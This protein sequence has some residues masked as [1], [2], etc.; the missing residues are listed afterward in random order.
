MIV[1]VALFAIFFAWVAWKRIRSSD[2]L[3]AGIVNAGKVRVESV[4][5]GNEPNSGWWAELLADTSPR[6]SKLKLYK[7]LDSKLA[8][9]LALSLIHI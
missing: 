1:V 8:N 4:S 2:R 3:D 7:S 5:S 9:L 6:P